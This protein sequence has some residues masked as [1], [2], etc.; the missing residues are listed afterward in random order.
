[1]VASIMITEVAKIWIVSPSPHMMPKPLFLVHGCCTLRGCVTRTFWSCPPTFARRMDNSVTR[2]L[3]IARVSALDTVLSLTGS[4]CRLPTEKARRATRR[5][6][7]RQRSVW[8]ES[9]ASRQQRE[10]YHVNARMTRGTRQGAQRWGLLLAAWMVVVVGL[11][12]CAGSQGGVSPTTAPK[13]RERGSPGSPV[14][15]VR[16]TPT[17]DEYAAFLSDPETHAALEERA[18]WPEV[19]AELEKAAAGEQI[20]QKHSQQ[21]SEQLAKA[22][23]SLHDSRSAGKNPETSQ[24]AITA[25]RL[26]ERSAEK[27]GRKELSQNGA[28]TAL[29]ELKQA[30]AGY[31]ERAKAEETRCGST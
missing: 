22:I 18:L 24:L 5:P 25:M 7:R 23:R 10:T 8:G 21:L 17:C 11:T 3:G 20:D 26:S 14:A 19:I 13:R 16:P 2:R 30:I 1:M 12:A 28:E 6:C 29:A 15:A 27:L 9:R 31:E 4:T